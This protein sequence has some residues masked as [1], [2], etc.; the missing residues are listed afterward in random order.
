MSGKSGDPHVDP[1]AAERHPLAL[2]QPPL[3]LALGQRS[4]GADDRAATGTLGSSQAC[5]TAPATR[6]APGETSP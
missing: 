2:Q 6:G 5:S 3:A 4:V 1:L